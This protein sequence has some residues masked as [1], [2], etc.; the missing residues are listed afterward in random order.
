[1]PSKGH[2]CLLCSAATALALSAFFVQLG[3]LSQRF[4]MSASTLGEESAASADSS[5]LAGLR[6]ELAAR[7]GDG[8]LSAA[9]VLALLEPVDE[10]APNTNENSLYG[11]SLTLYH[12]NLAE[13]RRLLEQALQL[14]PNTPETHLAHQAVLMAEGRGEDAIQVG[15]KAVELQP[16]T[17]AAYMEL[18]RSHLLAACAQGC[19]ARNSLRE[20]KKEEK[21]RGRK[22]ALEQREADAVKHEERKAA[23]DKNGAKGHLTQDRGALRAGAMWRIMEAGRLFKQGMEAEPKSVRA[24]QL[25]RRSRSLVALDANKVLSTPQ[26][27]EL[28]QCHFFYGQELD[29]ELCDK[30]RYKY[31]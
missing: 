29:G 31:E 26:V 17:A 30:A 4:G 12:P 8:N 13:A 15:R 11:P 6:H 28:A 5:S 27:I 22:S 3:D 1:M 7:P 24:K 23:R 20:E 14:A 19:A 25:E 10:V 18:A 9:L 16:E 21:K 2:T